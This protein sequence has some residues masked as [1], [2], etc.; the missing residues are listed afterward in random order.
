MG[1]DARK[2]CAHERQAPSW[3]CDSDNGLS[4]VVS[5]PGLLSSHGKWF[6]LRSLVTHL[7]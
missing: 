4:N 7:I 1:R 3:V 5:P 2:N 6:G